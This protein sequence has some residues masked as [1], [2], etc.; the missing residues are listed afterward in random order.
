MSRKAT[1][2]LGRNTLVSCLVF[3][4]SIG[5]LWVLVEYFQVDEV[6]AAAIGFIVANTLHYALGRAWIFEGTDRAVATGYVLFLFNSGVGLVLTV[7]LYAALLRFTPIDYLI[8]RVLVSLVA[9][10][11]IFVLNATLNFRRL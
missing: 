4:L 8:A 6:V 11:I 3:A 2:M 10:L 5:L 7:A 1:V 9:G